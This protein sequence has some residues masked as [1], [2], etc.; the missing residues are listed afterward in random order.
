MKR[1][2]I[3]TY[4]LLVPA[5]LKQIVPRGLKAR[6]TGLLFR[7]TG[8][9]DF[10]FSH[11]RHLKAAGRGEDAARIYAGLKQGNLEKNYSQ[12]KEFELAQKLTSK[13]KAT[14]EDPLFDCSVTKTRTPKTAALTL[15]EVFQA[16]AGPETTL[17]LPDLTGFRI[18]RKVTPGKTAD[19]MIAFDLTRTASFDGNFEARGLALYGS[20]IRPGE[21]DETDLPEEVIFYLDGRVLHR[22]VLPFGARTANFSLLIG[23]PV[24]AH[25]PQ[26]CGLE[27]RLSNG[28]DVSFRKGNEALLTLPH[29]DGRLLAVLE[30]GPDAAGLSAPLYNS[31]DP[32]AD[33]ELLASCRIEQK[34]SAGFD[35][36]FGLRGLSING[37]VKRPKPPAP[38]LIAPA[39]PELPGPDDVTV[40]STPIPTLDS[41]PTE[42]ALLLDEHVLYR[43]VLAF[44]PAKADFS[45]L[46]GWDLLAR[47]PQQARLSVRL[48]NGSTASFR[49]GRHAE[50]TVPHGDGNL[51]GKLQA[52]SDAPK[53][54]RPVSTS[55]VIP[56]A[57]IRN[58][59]TI[60]V[61]D[62]I[63]S[64][65]ANW[66]RSY[67]D[68]KTTD[69]TPNPVRPLH[70]KRIS[71]I[72]A[73]PARIQ[74]LTTPAGRFHAYFGYLGLKITASLTA[75][76]N[77]PP[78][79]LP[80]AL[81][82]MLDDHVLRPERLN[83]VRGKATIRFTAKRETLE[84]FPQDALLSIRTSQGGY[85]TYGKST[86]H[87]RLKVPHGD[88]S[89]FENLETVG[90]LN[91][92]GWPRL[93][94]EAMYEKQNRYLE[95]YTRARKAFMEEFNKP[96]FL[97][98]GTLLGQHRGGD[99]I[100]GDDD[101]DVG[102]VSEQTTPEAVKA[103][104]IEIMERLV[105]RGMIV[106]LNREGKPHRLRD[107][108]SGTEIHLDNRPVFTKG[109]G[110]VWLHKLARLDMSLDEFRNV[111]T[112]KL[113]DTK[114]FKPRGTEDFLAGYYGPGWRVP[115]PGFS[116]ASKVITP[117]IT[118]TLAAVCLSLDEQRALKTRLDARNLRGEFIPI[119]LQKLYPLEEYAEKVGF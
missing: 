53:F 49:G 18:Q 26:H 47:F 80:Q 41:T 77:L 21:I 58:A 42:W 23:W 118:R 56:D 107:A 38:V 32:E 105:K 54:K 91:K 95:L 59:C 70:V 116:N 113:R 8:H 96:L 13:G 84:M 55:S 11:A 37:S 50:V 3:S 82:I 19:Q 28:Q 27:I 48:S 62:P 73:K 33:A 34:S 97:L 7:I 78:E 15:P 46:I 31:D 94:P 101:F 117:D 106:L 9:P 57:D 104:A 74:V 1:F 67:I 87:L 25:F 45:L 63:D 10:G 102:Y 20:V 35:A 85:L 43:E 88:G 65:A 40:P 69:A 100:P 79:K 71:V 16:C 98:Y 111:E 110:H 90:P 39:P 6:M 81:E 29:G 17:P 93:S 75:P 99:F 12:R 108:E 5:R 22:K 4:R 30:P 36:I 2:L 92:K 109:D 44:G 64:L 66:L 51:L 114:I 52:K 89:I 72:P 86:T 76:R 119:A 60:A 14:I 61:K 115:D 68:G 83:F 112:A 103:E 24:L